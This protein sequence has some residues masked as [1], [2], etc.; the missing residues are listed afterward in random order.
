MPDNGKRSTVLTGTFFLC[1]FQCHT[2]IVERKME[3]LGVLT[4]KSKFCIINTVSNA[5]G[6]QH[7]NYKVPKS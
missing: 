2:G 1:Y 7:P 5:D 3:N 6:I 4:I